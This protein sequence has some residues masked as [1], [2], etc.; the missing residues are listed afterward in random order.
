MDTI[1]LTVRFLNPAFLGDGGQR[2]AWRAP[3]FKAQLR[4]WWRVVQARQCRDWQALRAVE[5]DLFGHAA[6]EGGGKSRVR[7]RLAPWHAGRMEAGQ[8]PTLGKVG[9]GGKGVDGGLYLGYGPVAVGPTLQKPPAINAGESAALRL[10][11]PR[12]ATP[13][14]LAA[15]ALMHGFGTVGGRSR[16]AWGS[17]VLGGDG[18]EALSP[19]WSGHLIDWC[20]ALEE[21]WVRGIGRDEKG[22]L[23]WRT[24][25]TF[26][27]WQHV[28]SA[29]AGIRH[30]VNRCARPRELLSFPVTGLHPRGWKNTDRLPSSLRLKV[31][32]DDEG[33]LRGQV[34]HLPCGLPQALSE[35]R[36][37][38]QALRT[39]WPTVHRALDGYKELQR[40]GA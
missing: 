35:R 33:K 39:L 10:A 40:V 13:A 1:S 22:P 26:A 14:L 37:D 31:V 8:W 23:V 20:E 38:E 27:D 18:A 24:R 34:A 29:L 36:G 9:N 16:N 11:W 32:Q 6:G 3:P 7:L 19:D 12:E 17:F 4:Q 28:M 30:H 25:T 15:L 21:S 5:N 2:G